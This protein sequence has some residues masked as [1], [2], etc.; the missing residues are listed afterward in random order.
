MKYTIIIPAYNAGKYINRCIDS[1]VDYAPEII[2]IN[3]GSTDNTLECLKKYKSIRII[4]NTNHGVSYSRNI[5]IQEA[6]NE[7][8]MFLDADDYINDSFKKN[9]DN[10]ELN[11]EDIVY[12]CTDIPQNIS[13]NELYKHITGINIPCIAGPGS[14]LYKKDFII[15][16]DIRF[17]ESIIN[18]EDMLFNF[19]C[20]TKTNNFKIINLAIYMY[21]QVMAS[22]TRRFDKKIIDSDIC[23]H[24][25]LTNMLTKTDISEE[26]KNNIANFCYTNAILMIIGRLSYLKRYI[27][28]KKGIEKLNIPF[29]KDDKKNIIDKMP[30][31]KRLIY[32]LYIKKHYYLL[33][34]IL[35]YKNSRIKQSEYFINI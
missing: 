15:K 26:E 33:Y 8:I 28:F 34:A 4:N 14:K 25:E 18:G 3:D 6:K 9:I 32:N 5:G 11:G 29:Y 10:I 13:K 19:D 2:V 21:R 12:F 23:F 16:N 30:F 22:A 27:D 7:Y 1:I 31:K 17:N 35:K 24:N 20:L